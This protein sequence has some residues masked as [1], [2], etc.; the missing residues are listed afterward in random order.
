[1]LSPHL[2]PFKL[3]ILMTPTEN[4]QRHLDLAINEAQ[5]WFR[6]IPKLTPQFIQSRIVDSIYRQ[7][8]GQEIPL[9][10]FELVQLNSNEYTVTVNKSAFATVKIGKE[11]VNG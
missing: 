4:I 10:Q 3:S 7:F 2:L 11:V 8:V 5:V 9:T 1:M 6:N